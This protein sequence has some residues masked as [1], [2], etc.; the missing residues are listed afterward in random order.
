LPGALSDD[1][2]AGEARKRS[3]KKCQQKGTVFREVDRRG[4]KARDGF[5]AAGRFGFTLRDIS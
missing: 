5:A 2:K 3:N 1:Y 4:G